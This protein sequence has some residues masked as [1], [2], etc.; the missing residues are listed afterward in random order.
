MVWSIEY[1][2]QQDGTQPAE[3][4]EDALDRRNLKLAGKLDRVMGQ[5]EVRGPQAGAGMVEKCHSYPGLWEARAI[6]GGTLAREL[7][8]FDGSRAVMLHGYLKRTGEPASTRD[9]ELASR[10]W[11]DYQHVNRT[12]PQQPEPQQE[13][14]GQ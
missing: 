2:E 11:Q 10:Y 13:E 6:F 3:V 1:Y 8:G 7:F 9:L 12:S 4:F 14:E 5:V